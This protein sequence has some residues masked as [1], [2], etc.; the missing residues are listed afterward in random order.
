MKTIIKCSLFVCLGLGL[1]ACNSDS[2]YDGKGAGANAPISG[3]QLIASVALQGENGEPVS[4]NDKNITDSFD[5]IDVD[6]L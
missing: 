4:V 5:P 1:V 3:E 6:S 2:K